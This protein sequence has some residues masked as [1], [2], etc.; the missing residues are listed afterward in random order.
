MSSAMTGQQRA[1]WPAA[2][3]NKGP[4]LEV[5]TRLVPSGADMLEVAS[6]TGQHAAHFAA[7]LPVGSYQPTD[8]DASHHPSIE[9]WTAGLA[10]VRP[11]VQLDTTADPWPLDQARY[12]VIYCA[13]MIHIAPFAACKGLVRGAGMHLKP[14]GR[15]VL[16][17]PFKIDGA[18]TADSNA[19]FDTRLQSQNPSWGVRDLS[20]VTREAAGQ[21]LQQLE[22]I[23]MPANNQLVVFARQG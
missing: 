9:A 22:R 14:N 10:V 8:F 21:G 6:G 4:I 3:R 1:I 18:H 11:V 2:D 12:D 19:A 15:L 23:S 7:A 16:Y 20:E 5:L 17:G 13:N